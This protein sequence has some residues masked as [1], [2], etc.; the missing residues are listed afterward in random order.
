M[1]RVMILGLIILSMA[2]NATAQEM[3]EKIKRLKELVEAGD[4]DERNRLVSELTDRGIAVAKEL[5][6]MRKRLARTYVKPKAAINEETA[7]KVCI[8]VA[9]R[10][11]EIEK[12]EGYIIRFVSIKPR[13]PA[14]AP[15]GEDAEDVKGV[16]RHLDE[17]RGQADDWGGPWIDGKS[18]YRYMRPIFAEKPCLSCHGD[19]KKVPKFIKKMYPDDK[20]F[21]FKEGDLMGGVAVYTWK[22]KYRPTK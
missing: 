19:E 7:K 14:N 9:D 16:L 8:A 5:V 21:G 11:K 1:K 18:Y 17:K 2:A 4:I 10:G 13:N 3:P 20:S 12:D 22:G 6:D 15:S